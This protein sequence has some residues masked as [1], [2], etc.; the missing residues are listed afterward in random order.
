MEEENLINGRQCHQLAPLSRDV[1]WFL[2]RW[3]IWIFVLYFC[4]LFQKRALYFDDVPGILDYF[5][6][7]WQAPVSMKENDISIEE[8]GLT[9]RKVV[10][11]SYINRLYILFHIKLLQI[12]PQRHISKNVFRSKKRFQGL[13]KLSAWDVLNGMVQWMVQRCTPG[14]K[15][16]RKVC[17]GA[18]CSICILYHCHCQ[19]SWIQQFCHVHCV[20]HHNS[21][22]FKNTK[23]FSMSLSWCVSDMSYTLFYPIQV[24]CRPMVHTDSEPFPSEET[25]HQF[26]KEVFLNIQKRTVGTPQ[27]CCKMTL[28]DIS[29]LS[30]TMKKVL[31]LFWNHFPP[32]LK[33]EVDNGLVAVHCSHG[34]HRWEDPELMIGKTVVK[35]DVIHPWLSFEEHLW[36]MNIIIMHQSSGAFCVLKEWDRFVTLFLHILSNFSFHRGWET[37]EQAGKRNEV[38]ERPGSSLTEKWGQLKNITEEFVDDMSEIRQEERWERSLLLKTTFPFLLI[39][40]KWN[41][42]DH[43]R[44]ELFSSI[45]LWPYMPSKNLKHSR[46]METNHKTWNYLENC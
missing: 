45:G 1:T 33:V 22:C 44:K 2:W 46:T 31:V 6:F 24:H 17:F 35:L 4:H 41:N 11:I 29:C 5:V 13:S 26:F 20:A 36:N 14:R 34:L 42:K 7:V 21:Y 3:G 12:P 28:F 30:K 39:V 25:V 37:Q 8:G 40:S 19:S 32:I 15:W 23:S 18:R 27:K 43:Q 10:V 16:Q 9:I 38:D